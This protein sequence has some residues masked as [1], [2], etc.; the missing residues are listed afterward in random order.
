MVKS[1]GH[2]V[3]AMAGNEAEAVR[4]NERMKPGL[5][6]MDVRLGRDPDGVHDAERICSKDPFRS[7]S[8]QGFQ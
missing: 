7:S 3:V 6:L 8:A 4:L 5:V 1:L 2:S